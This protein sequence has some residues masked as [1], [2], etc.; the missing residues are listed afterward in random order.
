[1]NVGEGLELSVKKH[2]DIEER[3]TGV[4]HPEKT[5][6]VG[7]SRL[8]LVKDGAWNGKEARGYRT[9]KIIREHRKPEKRRD[10]WGKQEDRT[11]IEGAP[12]CKGNEKSRTL[13]LTSE[14]DQEGG[15]GK[16]GLK[17]EPSKAHTPKG[18]IRCRRT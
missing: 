6:A 1:M 13:I 9:K 14:V 4:C 5:S 7:I 11:F 2:I 8:N 3:L 15:V 12:Y 10:C 18:G 17:V 16:Q